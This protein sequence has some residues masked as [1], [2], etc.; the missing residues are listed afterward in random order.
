MTNGLDDIDKDAE[1]RRRRTGKR[2]PGGPRRP[3]K[4]R[5]E[6]EA[7]EKAA[8]DQREA[9]RQARK[10]AAEEAA[11]KAAEEE[12]ARRAAEEEAAT[13]ESAKEEAAPKAKPGAK[14]TRPPS[15]PF[16]YDEDN[17]DFLWRIADAA[18]AMRS[19]VP[20]AAVLRLALRRLEQEM[21]PREIVQELSGPVQTEGKLG[22]PRR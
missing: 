10:A 14:R 15:I 4:T 21:T 18:T 11:R 2:N 5:E 20:N 12:A 1:E 6:R 16:Y 7:E 13:E 9:E 8:Q 17:M 3:R 22:R 19:K